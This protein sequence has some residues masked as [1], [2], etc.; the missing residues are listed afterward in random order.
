MNREILFE[1]VSSV[2]IRHIIDAERLIHVPTEAALLFYEHN[3]LNHE[4]VT[5]SMRGYSS[6]MPLFYFN[7][8]ELPY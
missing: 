1:N 8:E 2:L 3:F 4:W 6:T 5:Y 7:L